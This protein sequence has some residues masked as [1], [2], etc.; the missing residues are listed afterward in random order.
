MCNRILI[1]G[2]GIA[3][4]TA[5]ETARS[6]DPTAEI[7]ICE[8]TDS[9][10]YLRP[11]LSKTWLQS[12]RTDALRI[13][14][15]DWY[16]QHNIVLRNNMKAVKLES[17]TRT[18]FFANGETM[19]YDKLIYACGAAAAVPPIPGAELPGV[20]CLRTEEDARRIRMACLSAKS[21]VIIGGGIIGVEQ[22]LELREAGLEVAVLEGL[23]RFLARFLDE[24]AAQRLKESIEAAD[25][26]C[27]TGVKI[28]G[29]LPDV[30]GR[31]A[32]VEYLT[33]NGETVKIEAQ[34]VLLACGMKPDVDMLAAAGAQINRGICIN[35]KMETGIPDVYAAGDCISWPT[36]NPGLWNFASESARIAG[37]QAVGASNGETEV[38]EA[39][40]VELA[41]NSEKLFIYTVG[42]TTS[43][44]GQQ[45][46]RD[47][48]YRIN[49]PAYCAEP[50]EKLSYSPD[51]ELVGV[52]L[53]NSREGF[54][55]KRGKFLK[56]KNAV[57]TAAD[58]RKGFV[59][60]AARCIGCKACQMACKDRNGLPTGLYFRRAD[61]VETAGQLVRLSLSCSHCE[62]PACL[63]ACRNDAYS[64]DENG[65]VLHDAG[66]CIG[67]G[68]CAASC[69]FGSIHMNP[70]TGQAQKCDLCGGD[71]AC[72][73]ACPTR[74]VQFE[75]L[76][77]DN[78]QPVFLADFGLT[79]PSLRVINLNNCLL[80]ER[81]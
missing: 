18:V 60:N 31:A 46:E 32:A 61:T 73:K 25:V 52:T 55:A 23:P 29:I 4:L 44:S 57:P 54:A 80:A 48:N 15:Q 71:P 72:V 41:L 53:L 20:V 50:Y 12:L 45:P 70:V 10:P 79:E 49:K 67:C 14:D 77:E 65:T 78:G 38:F 34:L 17:E 5:A 75:E 40:L 62:N 35:E 42:D 36:G 8:Q 19:H 51:G 2:G 59:L 69:P 76:G 33:S 43:G 56:P 64:I 68:L 39:P 30:S 58:G 3:G 27:H 1:I 7:I 63:A 24:E 22:A 66:K 13:H 11:R 28:T 9:A 47:G 6:E 37:L 26:N 74:A 16:L 21:A 81:S